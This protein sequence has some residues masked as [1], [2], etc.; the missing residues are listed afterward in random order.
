MKNE[1]KKKKNERPRWP[2]K[3]E[4]HDKNYHAFLS[5]IESAGSNLMR[6]SFFLSECTFWFDLVVLFASSLLC[7][8]LNV[9][10]CS[11]RIHVF[12]HKALHRAMQWRGTCSN[13]RCIGTLK[14]DGLCVSRGEEPSRIYLAK[15]HL[16]LSRGENPSRI[17]LGILHSVL[18][19][20][21]LILT[22]L[23]FLQ[24]FS[25]SHPLQIFFTYNTH[26]SKKYNNNKAQHVLIRTY[27]G[28]K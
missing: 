13:R 3:K 21:T 2:D 16:Y 10:C 4:L 15:L 27:V 17:Y 6:F 5:K 28:I 22:C 23:L 12:R 18:P 19:K 1:T 7:L 25:F 14:I 8:T 24:I 20:A 26:S 11:S 9:A